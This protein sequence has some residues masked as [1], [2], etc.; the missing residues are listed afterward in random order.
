MK[1]ANDIIEKN[2]TH[3]PIMRSSTKQP[4]PKLFQPTRLWVFRGFE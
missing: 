3:T 1:S 2:A 4:N